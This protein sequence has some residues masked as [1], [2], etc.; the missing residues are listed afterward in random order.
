LELAW[1]FP[2]SAGGCPVGEGCSGSDDLAE[3]PKEFLRSPNE[4]IGIDRNS[5]IRVE[6][7]LDLGFVCRSS[8]RR[9][10]NPEFTE[11]FECR[12]E[13]MMVAEVVGAGL[14]KPNETEATGLWMRN[15]KNAHNPIAIQVTIVL[16]PIDLN[17]RINA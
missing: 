3:I 16:T 9:S 13:Q 15:R 6:I 10:A 1:W 12:D 7:G 2:E 17:P 4:M 14:T 8:R 5:F 11:Q